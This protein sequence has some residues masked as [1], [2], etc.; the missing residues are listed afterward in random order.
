MKIFLL[1]LLLSRSVFSYVPTFESFFRNGGN[2]QIEPTAVFVSAILTKMNANNIEKKTY[3]TNEKIYVR[4]VWDKVAEGDY[5]LRQ[6]LFKDKSLA[7]ESILEVKELGKLNASLFKETAI[8]NEQG[9][10]YSLI[11]ALFI[12]NSSLM[13][14]Y[15]KK[16]GIE[17]F[18][19]KDLINEEKRK[20]LGELKHF[21]VEKKNGS[22]EIV[23]PLSPKHEEYQDNVQLMRRP[24]YEDQGVVKLEL[25]E[26]GPCLHAKKD[27]FEGFLNDIDRS[28]IKLQLKHNAGSLEV[29]FS[30]YRKM[31]GNLYQPVSFVFQDHLDEFTQVKIRSIRVWS[32]STYKFYQDEKKYSPYLR[33]QDFF[34]PNLLL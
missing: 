29:S 7:K 26:N 23:S 13:V 9:F 2:A 3:T 8:G 11:E 25:C 22:E 1:G 14:D 17:I 12:N 33:D 5:R 20:L 28:F 6:F 15:L 31:P 16:V 10:F 21:F 24:L 19:N 27:G 32:E 4:W 18:P 30:S 34:R